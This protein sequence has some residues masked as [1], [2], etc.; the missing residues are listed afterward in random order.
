MNI[1]RWTTP[2]ITYKPSLVDAADIA[3][4]IMEISQGPYAI[5][6]TLADAILS[7]GRYYWRLTQE[8]TGGLSTEKN[9]KLQID[10]LS[11]AGDRYTTQKILISVI[12][13]AIDEVIA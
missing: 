5:V 9:C 8:E 6:K 3:E 11:N 2:S 10:Y 4:I 12:N 1:A 13:S 7:D